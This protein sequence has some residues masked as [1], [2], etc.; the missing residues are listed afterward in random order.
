MNRPT[1]KSYS[2][3]TPGVIYCYDGQLTTLGAAC[4]PGTIANSIGQLT[5]VSTSASTTQ[6][7][8][9][10]SNGRVTQSQQSTG[11]S[12]PYAF[13]YSYNQAGLLTSIHY[14]SGRQVTYGY[15]AANRTTSV[16]GLLAATPTYYTSNANPSGMRRTAALAACPV[17]T[18][19][20]R[21]P[22]TIRACRRRTSKP[23]AC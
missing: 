19:S 17:A 11:G 3:G 15:D 7:T 9:F 13:S 23:E 22:V 20:P 12:N 4:S 1:S 6:Y 10:D 21:R 18:G 2:D 14:P 8:Q 16:T 5:A